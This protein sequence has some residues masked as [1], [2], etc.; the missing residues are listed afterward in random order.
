[1]LTGICPQV[2]L[3]GKNIYRKLVVELKER[4]SRG[5]SGL[6]IRNGAVVTR[7]S[8][9]DN[10]SSTERANHPTQSS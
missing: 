4:R 2:N 7:P 6:I 10:Q 3:K 5:E 1:M 9:P 8:R